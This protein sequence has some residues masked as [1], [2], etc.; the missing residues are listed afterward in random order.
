MDHVETRWVEL[1]IL[2]VQVDWVCYAT[3]EVR[4]LMEGRV[5]VRLSIGSLLVVAFLSFDVV[6]EDFRD[7]CWIQ[8]E[9]LV[10]QRLCFLIIVDFIFDWCC[11]FALLFLLSSFLF[12]AAT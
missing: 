6:V 2:E 12:G 9:K 3:G 4:G 1:M 8:L 5:L 7:F 10:Y 11:L